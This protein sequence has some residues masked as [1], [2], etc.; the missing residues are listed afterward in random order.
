MQN[1]KML[2]IYLHCINYSFVKVYPVELNGYVEVHCSGSGF[3]NVKAGTI[4]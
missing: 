2:T 3:K 4:M 1:I